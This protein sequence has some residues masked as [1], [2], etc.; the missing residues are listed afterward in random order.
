MPSSKYRSAILLELAKP[1]L[2]I[3]LSFLFVKTDRE[4]DTMPREPSWG[5]GVFWPFLC[6][7]GGVWDLWS[8]LCGNPTYAF[9]IS[10]WVFVFVSQPSTTSRKSDVP[11]IY[12]SATK[13]HS[14]KGMRITKNRLF[15]AIEKVDG[16]LLVSSHPSQ[17]VRGQRTILRILSCPREAKLHCRPERSNRPIVEIQ[18]CNQLREN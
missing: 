4:K 17:E 14:P 6:L 18:L 1:S 9:H 8:V 11:L 2:K 13:F 15:T 12:R 10:N 3:C 7:F 5:P 16:A